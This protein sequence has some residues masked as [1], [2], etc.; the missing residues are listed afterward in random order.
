LNL[1]IL[2]HNIDLYTFVSLRAPADDDD[3]VHEEVHRKTTTVYR[4]V[5]HFG[6]HLKFDVF[7]WG[8]L[9]LSAYVLKK[10]YFA[11]LNVGQLYRT[12]THTLYTHEYLG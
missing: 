1:I 5:Q 4:V 11:V 7:V 3:V 2:W 12:D 10:I 6:R 9:N 8:Y